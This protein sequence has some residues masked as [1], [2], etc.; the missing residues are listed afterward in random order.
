MKL[1]L[2]YLIISLSIL[3]ASGGYDHGTSAGKGNL[4][5]SLTW[6]PFNY[7]DQGQSYVV[8]GYGFTNRLDIHAY[9]SY[10]QES[11]NSNYYVGLFYQFLNSKYLDLSTAI[12]IRNFTDNSVKHIFFP[13][14][15]YRV[16]FTEKTSI[17]GSFVNIKKQKNLKSNI[18]T[19]V[20]IF[21]M[22]DLYQSKKINI[23]LSLGLFN[24]VLW[25]PKKGNWHPTYSVDIN[26]R[27]CA[28]F[29]YLLQSY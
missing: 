28:G 19:A 20:D 6:N 17:A 27:L 13:Q 25:T 8:I 5:L 11:R 23:S 10:M 18:G 15:L 2:I 3:F 12:G 21:L 22:Q 26:F 29:Y 9:Y 1:K 4:D 16:Y 7:F 24:P 14:F